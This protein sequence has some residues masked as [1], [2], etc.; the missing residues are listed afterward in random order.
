MNQA[1]E[2]VAVSVSPTPEVGPGALLRQTRTERQLSL[3]NAAQTLRLA[4]KQLRALEQD[5]YDRLP[6]PTYV[7]G[8]LRNYAQLLGL[9]TDTVLELYNRQPAAAKAVDLAKHTPTP[10]MS[11]DHRVIKI[12]TLVVAG[13]VLGLATIWW[14]GRDD[15]PIRLRKPAATAKVETAP[16]DTASLPRQDTVSTPAELRAPVPVED[17]LHPEREPARAPAVATTPMAPAG[18]RPLVLHFQQDSWADVRDGA[19][20]KLLYTTISAGR[21]IRLGGTPPFSVYLGNA[22]GVRVEYNGR[23]V[24]I[25]RYQRGPIARL[26]VGNGTEQV[27]Q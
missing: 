9:S 26:T 8:Y 14:Q 12:T 24:D 1:A 5:D 22:S 18:P 25:S 3:E 4:P 7:R 15:S 20:N 11:S 21:V 23:P 10:Q 13:L 2:P 27:A 6:G 17:G 19:Q 16:A